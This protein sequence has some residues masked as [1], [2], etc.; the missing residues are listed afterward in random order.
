MVIPK[1]KPRKDL[2]SSVPSV[3]RKEKVSHLSSLVTTILNNSDTFCY[4][5]AF[6]FHTMTILCL[7]MPLLAKI[8]KIVPSV[9]IFLNAL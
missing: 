9:T 1:M 2:T 5:I 4:I 7:H 8:F 6:Y 3:T